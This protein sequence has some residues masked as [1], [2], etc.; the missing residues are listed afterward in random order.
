MYRL[1]GVWVVLL[2]GV[3]SGCGGGAQEN[4]TAEGETSASQSQTLAAPEGSLAG[5]TMALGSEEAPL[6]II[7]YASV[8]CPACAA[9]HAQYFPEIKEKYIDTG[10]V[11]FIYREFPTAPQNL[12]YAGFY[13]ARCAATDRGPVAYFAMLDTLY[14]RQR[15]WAYGDNPGDVLENIAAQAGIDR[16]ELETCFRRE[17]IRSAVKANVLEGVEAHG[18]NSTPTFIVDDE[19]LD[20]NRGSETMS[21]AIERALAARQG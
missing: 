11:R 7:E 20:W 12:A 3:L 4:A 6:T 17:D 16:Q 21:E 9:F 8:T 19:E 5:A 1:V 14:A 13:T 10:K 2:A 18:V 15:E